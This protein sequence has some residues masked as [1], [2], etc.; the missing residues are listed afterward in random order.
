MDWRAFRLH[1]C[2][3]NNL[4][5]RARFNLAALARTAVRVDKTAH[6]ASFRK[7]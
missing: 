2:G 3:V 4:L 1:G 6:P 7:G 5:S